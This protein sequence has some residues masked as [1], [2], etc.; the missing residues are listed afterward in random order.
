[1][2]E[3]RA[4][5]QAAEIPFGTMEVMPIVKRT[6]LIVENARNIGSGNSPGNVNFGPLGDARM[7]AWGYE[8]QFSLFRSF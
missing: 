8:K 4:L 1:V 5:T 7:V 2:R 3:T 6:F